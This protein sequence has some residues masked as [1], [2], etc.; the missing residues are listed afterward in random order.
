VVQNRLNQIAV[1]TLAPDLSSGTVVD[2]ITSPNFDVPTTVASFGNALYAVNARFSTPATPST[3]Y[4][5][6]RVVP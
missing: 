3:S 2:N 1:V 4:S 5:I 6:V